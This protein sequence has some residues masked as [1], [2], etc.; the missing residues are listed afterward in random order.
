MSEI[1][2]VSPDLLVRFLHVAGAVIAVGAVT[3]TDTVN[4]VPHFRPAFAEVSARVSSLFSLLIWIGFAML[5]GTGLYMLQTLPY[6]AQQPLFRFK[7]FLVAIIFLNG[8]FLNLW[9]TPGFRQLADDWED[10]SADQR[11]FKR[12]AGAA[13]G[14]SLIGWWSL[15]FLGFIIVRT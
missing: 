10:E 11:R 12:I 15:L 3:V 1:L 8:L 13:A 5:S 9:V 6:L 14:I 7:M 4:I 2:A